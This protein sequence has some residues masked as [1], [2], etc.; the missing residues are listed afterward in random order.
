M[1]DHVRCKRNLT[2]GYFNDFKSQTPRYII[3][4]GQIV[5]VQEYFNDFKNK[6]SRYMIIVWQT[7]LGAIVT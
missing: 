5:E 2:I 3:I 1:E 4:V 6:T 7:T